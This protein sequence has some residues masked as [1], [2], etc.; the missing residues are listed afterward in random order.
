MKNPP[1]PDRSVQAPG[2]SVVKEFRSRAALTRDAT[3][4]YRPNVGDRAVQRF[5][6]RADRAALSR[7]TDRK[8]FFQA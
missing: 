1:Q 6:Q 5:R 7:T 3:A 2:L 4:N 8:S